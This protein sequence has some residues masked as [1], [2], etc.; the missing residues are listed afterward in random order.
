MRPPT[1][2]KMDMEVIGT[3]GESAQGTS[4][5]AVV[6]P[7]S[8]RMVQDHRSQSLR[9]FKTPTLR[10]VEYTGP[11]MHN[12]VFATLEQVVDFYDAGGGVGVGLD[13]PNQTLSTDSL[14]LDVAEKHAL[15]VF[16]KALSDTAGMMVRPSLATL[17]AVG[18]FS[19][20]AR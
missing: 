7:D 2:A 6:D 9:S 19:V 17:N 3:P 4:G 20:K 16:L 11:Y 5:R 15:V 14:H 10:N 18:V 8:G 12:G 1:F 13:I